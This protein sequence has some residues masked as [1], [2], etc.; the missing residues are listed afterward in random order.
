MF[1]N[2]IRRLAA[3][4]S[5]PVAE[6]E[7]EHVEGLNGARR[8]AEAIGSG[9]FVPDRHGVPQVLFERLAQQRLAQL[10][11]DLGPLFPQL[12]QRVRAAADGFVYQ[13][14]ELLELLKDLG[15][16]G[17]RFAEGAATGAAIVGT[18]SLLPP[19]RSCAAWACSLCARQDCGRGLENLA[20]V[21]LR[22]VQL[23]EQL[24]AQRRPVVEFQFES[25][26]FDACAERKPTRP[27]PRV[28]PINRAQPSNGAGGGNSLPHTL[29]TAT[30]G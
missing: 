27:P 2:A 25:P 28:R 30:F 4:D 3:G 13:V 21:K 5:R 16:L 15:E 12:F 8:V 22:G 11:G 24:K 9:A 7:A 6:E 29:S 20:V 10:G 1:P 26:P 19:N 18:A 17:S 23:F 14:V